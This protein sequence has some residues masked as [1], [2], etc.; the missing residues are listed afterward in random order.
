MTDTLQQKRRDA[1]KKRIVTDVKRKLDALDELHNSLDPRGWNSQRGQALLDLLYTNCTQALADIA[2][3][4]CDVIDIKGALTEASEHSAKQA[5]TRL[6][7]QERARA[8][9]ALRDA[10]PDLSV[11]ECAVLFG[12]SASGFG[13][14]VGEARAMRERCQ[15]GH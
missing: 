11:A 3:L 7:H 2:T 9:L 1:H 5:A 10:H 6:K 14:L 8:A 13:V 12:C 4:Q 15:T